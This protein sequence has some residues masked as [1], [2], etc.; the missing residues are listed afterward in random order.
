MTRT[1]DFVQVFRHALR[2]WWSENNT[3]QF[4]AAMGYYAVF[5]LTP[6]A[7]ISV[8][9]AGWLFGETAAEGELANQIEIVVGPTMAET[10]QD[11]ITRAHKSESGVIAT[12]IG[13]GVMF[14]GAMGVF[15]QL[16]QA[17]NFI[18][19][20][21]LRPDRGILSIVW[22]SVI[23]FL[24]VLSGGALLVIALLASTL[25]AYLS[26]HLSILSVP[27]GITVWIW[28]DWLTSFLLLT[29]HFA[30]L[31]KMLPAV[32]I[33]WKVVWPGAFVTAL[34]FALGNYVIG[35]YLAHTTD[36][37][38]FGAAG[39]LVLFLIWVYFAS[40]VVLFGA[41]LT[42]AYAKHFGK[43]ITPAKNALPIQ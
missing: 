39:S 32:R 19:G 29:L 13:L 25:V 37:S 26:Q 10:I 14:V 15:T 23:P 18:W 33:A 27:G 8:A 41:E 6:L 11:T 17:L 42:R 20:V 3:F 5:A 12:L 16:Q 40:Q 22:D 21:K 35:L 34:L 36:A 7:I 2:R 4:G 28:I 31:Y 30:M 43:P 1:R 38:A 24:M 9:M